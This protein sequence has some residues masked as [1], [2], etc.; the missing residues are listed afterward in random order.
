[1][2]TSTTFSTALVGAIADTWA[3]IRTRHHDVPDVVITVGAGAEGKSFRLGHFAAGAWQAGDAEVSELFVGGEGLA[4]GP[5]ELLTTLL[6]EAAHGVAHTRGIQDT[7]RQGRYHNAH[8]LALG[9]ELGLSVGRDDTIGW[10]LSTLPDTTAASYRGQLDALTAALTA[11]RRRLG[12]ARDPDQKS[13]NGLA[14][15]CYCQRKIRVSRST[16]NAGPILCGLCSTPF[17][18]DETPQQETRRD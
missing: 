18:A 14:A 2:A 1:M 4:Q 15:V 7:S 8:Y 13:N 9:T 16:Y 10:S 12:R 17:V 11:H 6:H 3:E 5:G